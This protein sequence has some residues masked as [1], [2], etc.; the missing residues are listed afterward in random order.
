METK[1][2]LWIDLFC[3]SII[4]YKAGRFHVHSSCHSYMVKFNNRVNK[5]R[6]TL[7]MMIQIHCIFVTQ[8]QVRVWAWLLEQG[9]HGTIIVCS[10][11][12]SARVP[13]SAWSSRLSSSP[14]HTVAFHNSHSSA[15]W[16]FQS[17]FIKQMLCVYSYSDTLAVERLMWGENQGIRDEASMGWGGELPPWFPWSLG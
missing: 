7:G 17:Q 12:C 15:I 10:Q 14:C 16:I 2:C 5:N 13:S 9:Q 6:N 4:I 11:H 3:I 8:L 1:Q